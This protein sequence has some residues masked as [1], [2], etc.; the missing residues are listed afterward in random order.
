MA[1]INYAEKI[2]SRVPLTEALATY[3]FRLVLGRMPC[4]FHNGT[5]RNLSVKRDTFRCWVCGEHGDVISFVMKYFGL[6]FV[7][8]MQKLN[9]DFALG[10]PIRDKSVK[11]SIQ[12]INEANERQRK[13][14]ERK[15]RL[16]ALQSNYRDAFEAYAACDVIMMRCRPVSPTTLDTADAYAWALK[17]IDRCWHDLKIAEIELFEFERE[18]EMNETEE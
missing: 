12:M 5:D 7:D 11:P 2:K 10:L 9:E 14:K 1:R 17:N 6:S 8:A 15:E 16:D 4:P 13:A 3:G 18:E